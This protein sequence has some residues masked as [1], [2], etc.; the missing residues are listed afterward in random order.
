MK[1]ELRTQLVLSVTA[2]LLLSNASWAQPE[3][4]P[5]GGY[6]VD[7]VINEFVSL[8]HH[9]DPI[10][11]NLGVGQDSTLCKHYQGVVRHYGLDGTPYLII[12]RSGQ[13][14]SCVFCGFDCSDDPAEL[15]FARL[16]TRPKHGER[17][18]SNILNP[19]LSFKDTTPS[20]LD[21]IET[22]MVFNGTGN[23]TAWMHAGGM[24]LVDD[25]LIVPMERSYPNDSETGSLVLIDVIDPSNPQVINE[26]F[27][28]YQAGVFGITK[29]PIS[30]LYIIA[31]SGGDT[32]TIRWYETNSS[33]L[34]DPA[35]DL[36]LKDIW[37]VDDADVPSTVKDNWEKWQTLNFIR[38]TD[39]RL[40]MG[41]TDN[42]DPEDDN[43]GAHLAGLFEV[44][45]S[46]DSFNLF[47]W[48][49]RK[50]KL[51]DPRTGNAAASGGYY[52]SPSG[53]LI[54]YTTEHQN[55]GPNGSVR[56][57]EL[58]SVNVSSV[59]GRDPSS[60]TWI[61][62]YNDE[63]GWNDS[64]PDKSFM[65]DKFDYGLENWLDL[66][67]E[68][69]WGDEADSIR[70]RAPLGHDI[71]LFKD[72]NLNGQA[73]RLVGTGQVESISKL[74]DIGFGDS[75]HSIF[76][77]VLEVQFG[78]AVFSSVTVLSSVSNA[79][80]YQGRLELVTVPGIWLDPFANTAIGWGNPGPGNEILIHSRPNEQTLIVGK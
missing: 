48:T 2:T 40:F 3:L 25:I 56:A 19:D 63:S 7:N 59:D 22:S 79:L 53:Q 11:I 69:G 80:A 18:R 52:V 70:Y 29:D 41:T 27:L 36:I 1:R 65:L 12:S 33:D 42:T 45:R 76:A 37:H 73:F 75:I 16:G 66:D 28:P 72:Q 46:G 23:Q 20:S 58:R 47:Y 49:E 44:N 71:W 30:D 67:K 78:S 15:V 39:G 62:L 10:S 6:T 68:D 34:F 54:L 51:D 26:F 77:G 5:A 14:A 9:P 50:L 38:Q 74:D 57:G 43:D 55:N 13:R 4:P 24:Q 32:K 64:S 35:L 60:D 8:A 21:F 31:V 17:M 61:E